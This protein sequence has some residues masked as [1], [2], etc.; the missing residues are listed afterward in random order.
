[1]AVSI[2]KCFWSSLSGTGYKSVISFQKEENTYPYNIY[3]TNLE[4]KTTGREA[5][6]EE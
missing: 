4:E 6:S 2:P 3:K 5:I 1:M